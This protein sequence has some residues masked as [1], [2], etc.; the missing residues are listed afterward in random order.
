MITGMYKD[1]EHAVL[2]VVPDLFRKESL[3]MA[4]VGGNYVV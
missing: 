4:F 2:V 1:R 3:Q